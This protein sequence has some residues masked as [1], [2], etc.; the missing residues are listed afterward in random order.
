MWITRFYPH[1]FQGV[2]RWKFNLDRIDEK[3]VGENDMLFHIGSH[4]TAE[5]VLQRLF[6]PHT[7]KSC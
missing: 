7:W 1:Q 3:A 6:N 4:K 2:N 5:I